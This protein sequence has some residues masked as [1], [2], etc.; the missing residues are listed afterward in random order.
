MIRDNIKIWMG[1]KYVKRWNKLIKQSKLFLVQIP[2][3]IAK[4]KTEKQLRTIT[5][6]ITCHCGLKKH[7]QNKGIYADYVT[8]NFSLQIRYKEV[9]LH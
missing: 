7:L 8:H 2:R 4:Y 5:V 6:L 9:R 1:Q 3:E